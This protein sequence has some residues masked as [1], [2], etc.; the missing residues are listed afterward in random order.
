[1]VNI[2]LLLRNPNCNYS[3]DNDFGDEICQDYP[4]LN[5]ESCGW[6]NGDCPAPVEVYS[7]CVVREPFRI[8][9]GYCDCEVPYF[10]KECEWDGGDCSAEECLQG[11]FPSP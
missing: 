1:M 5:T 10:T 8:A 4:S 7:K 6:D 11:H 3:F 2:V 9:N